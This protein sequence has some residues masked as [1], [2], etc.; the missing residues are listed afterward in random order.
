MLFV[1]SGEGPTDLGACLQAYGRCCGED[2]APGP[3]M[4]LAFRLIEKV[5]GFSLR[6]YLDQVF[7]VSESELSRVAK[8]ELKP[9]SKLRQL[10]L[11]GVRTKSRGLRKETGYYYSNARALARVAGDIG[12]QNEAQSVVAIL[13]RDS[14]GTVSKGGSWEAKRQSMLDGFTEEGFPRGVPMIPKP[15]QEAWLICH[16]KSPPYQGCDALEARSGNDDSPNSL[17]AELADLISADGAPADLQALV[18]ELD[19]DQLEMPSFLAFRDRLLEA[20]RL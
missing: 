6:D 9:K 1:F 14:D 12:A 18:E 11:Q 15:K 8:S 17:K 4:S 3:M 20:L 2:L 7:L 16:L 19:L 10:T 13:F 5:L